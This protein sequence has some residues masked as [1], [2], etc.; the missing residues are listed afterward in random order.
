MT[1]QIVTTEQTADD[2]FLS[3]S[4]FLFK[5]FNSLVKFGILNLQCHLC[6]EECHSNIPGHSNI[7]VRRLG[8][9]C[10]VDDSHPI[11]VLSSQSYTQ[12]ELAHEQLQGS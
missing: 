5:A 3:W 11:F 12:K 9:P 4:F 8:S 1:S 7:A 2:D 6:F 10:L